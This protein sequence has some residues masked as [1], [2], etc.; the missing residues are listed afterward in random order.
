MD[1]PFE[2]GIDFEIAV[3]EV[4]ALRDAVIA[5]GHRPYLDLE[6]KW[7]R[8]GVIYVGN[9]QFLVQDP[10]GYLLRFAEDLGRRGAAP[11]VI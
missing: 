1:H 4:K 3:A 5:A 9:R 11:E 8:V 2:R 7:Y 10:D 6:E